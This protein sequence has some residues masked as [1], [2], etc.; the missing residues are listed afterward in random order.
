MLEVIVRFLAFVNS[1][2]CLFNGRTTCSLFIYLAF[3]TTSGMD[4]FFA[5]VSQLPHKQ[6]IICLKN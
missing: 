4:S 5:S 1:F 2:S 6:I 3:L